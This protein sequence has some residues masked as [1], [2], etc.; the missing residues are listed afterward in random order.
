MEIAIPQASNAQ[1]QAQ[2]AS[3]AQGSK[4]AEGAVFQKTLVQQLNNDTT[5]KSGQSKAT[6]LVDV[7]NNKAVVEGEEAVAS[8]TL[9]EL[10][11]IIDGLLDKLESSETADEETKPIDD[12]HLNQLSD[13]LDQMSALLALLGLPV[14]L[15]QQS[16]TDVPLDDSSLDVTQEL[17]QAVN[18]RNK[19]QDTLVQMQIMLN[20]GSM[21]LIH[22]QEPAIVVAQQLQALTAILEGQPVDTTKSQTKST[23]FTQQ[24]FTAQLAPQADT[25][26][27]L[28]RLSQQTA[29][30]MMFSTIAQTMEQSVDT[31]PAV[32]NVESNL[33][34]H[35]GTSN[36]E[37]IRGLA[38]LTANAPTATSY[39]VA[40][41]FAK[42]MT[43]MIVQKLDL[44][45][46]NG[47]SEA[48]IM[49]F[50]EHLGQVDVRITMQNGLLTAVFQTDTAMAKDMLDNQMAQLRSALQAQ[51]L[52]VDKLEVSQGQSTSQ[53]SQQQ[54]GQGS[55]QQQS[56][57]RQRFNHDESTSD[58]QFETEMVQ[59][60]TIQGLGFGRGINV[61]A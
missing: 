3:N 27:L 7:V 60:A 28:Q 37:T 33:Q 24:L 58:S 29:H 36:A 11:S 5:T 21:K 56:S 47:V 6:P 25:G 18:I 53:L 4:A 9:L 23:T 40:E 46:V 41:E 51:G 52:M 32:S 26:V 59:Q 35:L 31:D 2:A 17:N 48:K 30:P 42:S 13:M 1:P 44:T 34:L 49:L 15:V 38:P 50:P 12:E 54:Q 20:Q 22:Q 39:V 19:L 10:M 55:S 57:S 14:P 8:P 16:N 45:M 61:R 43:G